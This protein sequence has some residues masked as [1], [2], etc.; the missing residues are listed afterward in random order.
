MEADWYPD[1]EILIA[2]GDGSESLRTLVAPALAAWG[3]TA[4]ASGF[5]T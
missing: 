5:I 4:T 3:M 2:L 1:E